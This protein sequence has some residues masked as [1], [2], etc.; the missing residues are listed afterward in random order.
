[1]PDQ[2]SK[3]RIDEQQVG[4]VTVLTLHGEM[5]GDD[6]DL[7]FGRRVDEL[8][9][10]GRSQIVVNLAE[11]SNIDSSG[12]GMMVAELKMVQKQGGAMKLASL[13]ARSYHVLAMLKLKFIFEIFEDEA[14]AIR[15]FEW[16]KRS[17][18]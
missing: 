1:M 18:E 9:K 4:D 14:S 13:T 6:G 11:V 7:A 10:H 16:R 2:V 15:S 8:I 17:S 12:V 5:R 3:L